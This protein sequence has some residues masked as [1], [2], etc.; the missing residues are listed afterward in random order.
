MRCHLWPGRSTLEQFRLDGDLVARQGF[1]VYLNDR[2][3]QRGGWNGFVHADR[4]LKLARVAIDVSGDV[5]E[6]LSVKPEKN[7]IEPGPRFASLL[8]TATANDGATFSEYIDAARSTLKEANR[9][10]RQRPAR[11]PAG[12]GFD[13]RVRRAIEQEFPMKDDDPIDIRWAPMPADQFFELDRDESVI[14]LNKRYRSAILGGRAG[15]LNDAP[16]VKVLLYLLFEEIFA[17][18]NIGSRDRDNIALWQELLLTA[19][20]VQAR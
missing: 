16:L 14:W 20:E 5:P 17:G 18:Q 10:N 12:S 4:Q 1:Y 7:G 9:R 19:A 11:I 15:S 2:L 8:R 6:L 3:I 13:P